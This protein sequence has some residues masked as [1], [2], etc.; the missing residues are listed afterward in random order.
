MFGGLFSLI[1]LSWG[2]GGMSVDGAPSEPPSFPPYGTV[3]NTE[4]SVTQPVSEGGTWVYGWD[5]VTYYPSRNCDVEVKANGS[6][7]SFYDWAN[8]F[9]HTY[10]PYG[11]SYDSYSGTSYV[12]VNGTDYPN[13]NY[14]TEYHHDGWGGYYTSGYNN[15]SSNGDYIT[16]DSGNTSVYIEGSYYTN[17]SYSN[18]YFHDGLGGY[19]SSG[20]TDYYSYSSVIFNTGSGSATLS[21]P[22]GTFTYATWWDKYYYH[23]GNG[24]YYV[25]YS[26]YQQASY[27][28]WLG[29]DG[30]NGY[31]SAE[32]PYT[33]G[34]YYNY[35][36]W[37]STSYLYDGGSSYYTNREN[38]W[39]ALF[40]DYITSFEVDGITYNAYWDG[41][42][43]YYTI[44]V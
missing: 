42:G 35:E 17:G 12:N 26:N 16:G 14:Y 33:S 39:V 8:S 4:F 27:G 21:W 3:L 38:L 10:K 1:G 34:N 13:G 36:S 32:V 18:S 43:S 40:G 30:Q 28:T 20:Y 44:I 37:T 5:G 31:S 19:Y 15:Y 11:Q 7:G 24:S 9:N 29:N 22:Y 6:G 2:N 41:T 25:D 23:D